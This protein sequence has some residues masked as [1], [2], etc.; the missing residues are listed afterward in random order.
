MITSYYYNEQIKKSIKQFSAIFSGLNVMTGVR[1]DGK[2]ASIEVPVVYGMVDKVVSALGRGNTQNKLVTMPMIV[3]YLNAIDLAPHRR[4]GVGQTD[5]RTVMPHAG[6]YPQDL[7]VMERYMPIPYDLSFEV[8]VFS[9]N[10]DQAFQI[11]EQLMMVFDPTLQ[12]QVS[13]A[14]FDWT[15]HTNVEL[16]D[17][18]NEQSYPIGATDKRIIAWVMNFKMEIWISPPVDVKNELVKSITL[19]FGDYDSIVLNE[20]EYNTD[21]TPEPFSDGVWSTTTIS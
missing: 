21:G 13:E 1:E 8:A 14:S 9:T 18:G 5:R 4:K 19:R 16:L 17:I 7:K 15:A 3:T 20:Y 2:P 11:L 6:V 12:I 10:T